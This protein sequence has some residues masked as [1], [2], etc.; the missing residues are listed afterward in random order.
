MPT[1]E[2][3]TWQRSEY[4]P[5]ND[6]LKLHF[7]GAQGLLDRH[8]RLLREDTVGQLRDAVRLQVERLQNPI[9]SRAPQV[10]RPRNGARVHVYENIRLEKVTCPDQ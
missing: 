7:S 6:L 10:S 1:A 9:L 4:L 2:E 3:I 8:F 5:G